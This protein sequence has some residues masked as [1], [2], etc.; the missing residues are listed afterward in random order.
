MTA[1]KKYNF[2]LRVP[3]RRFKGLYP[4]IEAAF[5]AHDHMY[6]VRFGAEHP[7][8]HGCALIMLGNRVGG[9]RILDRHDVC[10]ARA[11]LY[12][13][14]GAWQDQNIEEARRWI[15]EGHRM[16]SDDVRF[17][18]L[19]KLIERQSFRMV[20]HSDFD[21]DHVLNL[22]RNMPGFDVVI[23]RTL[24]PDG[25]GTLPIDKPLASIIPPGPPI[26]FILLDDFKLVPLGIGDLGAPV[27]ANMHDHEWYYEFLDHVMSDIDWVQTI[28]SGEIVEFKE[29]FDVGAI[30][31]FYPLI[32]KTPDSVPLSKKFSDPG[33][34][35]IDLLSTGGIWHDFYRYKRQDILSLTQ[36]DDRFAVRILGSYLSLDE[37]W[38]QQRNARFTIASSRSGNYCST[39][40]LESLSCGALH[41]IEEENC[42]PYLFSE[43]F[44]CF[45]VYRRNHVL[46]D[47][48]NHL[49]RYDEI[50]QQLQ[51]QLP[52]LDAEFASVFQKD[53]TNR[54]LRYLRHLLFM[55]QV[56]N[57]GKRK[58]SAAAAP[59][60]DRVY[61][62]EH[63]YLLRAPAQM[64]RF[65]RQTRPPDFLRRA[66]AMSRKFFV[67]DKPPPEDV[68]ILIDTLAE[69]LAVFPDSLALHYTIGLWQRLLGSDE[70]AD[71][72]FAGVTSG[73]LRL[74]PDDPV[75]TRCS[76]LNSLY[77]VNDAHIRARCPKGTEPLA[78]AEHVLI[79]YAWANRADILLQQAQEHSRAGRKAE[80]IADL[81]T[82]TTY[83]QKALDLFLCNDGAQRVYLFAALG[84]ASLG[85]DEW[86]DI[87]LS[88]FEIACHNEY[89]FMTDFAMPAAQLLMQRQRLP[90]A[91]ALL[92]NLKRY[93][94]RV[95]HVTK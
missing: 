11:C 3:A 76:P 30:N 77:W 48:E 4:S 13:A 38:Q 74:L 42:F 8:L 87:F 91:K 71:K 40:A 44:A 23:T 2:P 37:F 19:A 95:G 63:D 25:P 92:H 26:D 67:Q 27:I 59:R 9:E 88:S 20:F 50:M 28:A 24:Q 79:S 14:F 29:A 39:R 17:E 32:L 6:V 70:A 16:G 1:L 83:V 5:A 68:K 10:T 35:T 62:N 73:Q 64:D 33:T 84:L 69:G 90:E 89:A 80:A 81:L 57:D 7:E 75:W 52:Q 31:Y 47:V 66:L 21:G 56:D 61:M 53:E 82:V 49:H 78:S 94:D 46:K 72:S 45:P 93:M 54:V 34:R 55:V 12:R 18:R 60:R 22:F 41:L 51:P 58:P 86:G 36:L 43:P 85:R 65:I 15:A